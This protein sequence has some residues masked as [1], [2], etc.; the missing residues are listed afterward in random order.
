MNI[1]PHSTV[2]YKGYDARLLRGF[3][4]SSNCGRIGN[5]MEKIGLKEGFKIFS[6]NANMTTPSCCEGVSK[7]RFGAFNMW[8]QDYWTIVKNK[9]LTICFDDKASAIKK[10]FNLKND[11]TQQATRNL[12]AIDAINNAVVD[13]LNRTEGRSANEPEVVSGLLAAFKL[14][15]QRAKISE[16][17][18]KTHIEGG[19]IYIVK[20]DNGSEVIVGSDRKDEFDEEDI[21][22]MYNAQKVTTLPM[23]DYHI[24][25]FIRPLNKKQI[26]LTDDD[27]TLE[28]L[29]KGY[30]KFS[31]FVKSL[32][33]DEKVMYQKRLDMMRCFMEEFANH[34][35]ENSMAKSS[36][37]ASVLKNNG[38]KVIRVPGRVYETKYKY[39]EP[40]GI[41]H[42]CN[43][44]NA[45][46]LENKDGELVYITNKSR[47]DE[48]LGLN[49]EISDKIGFSFETEFIKSISEY[50]KP[51][52]IYFVEGDDH[53]VSDKMLYGYQGGIHCACTEVPFE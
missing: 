44:I 46:V 17:Q 4:M 19:N 33:N 23:M 49:K 38:Y 52:H 47:V 45:N 3:L 42:Y 26:L 34:I 18:Y 7:D 31:S 11:I 20:G 25:L 30:H 22:A 29:K 2:S 40:V 9:L 28:V 10:F 53:Y 41:S 1:N 24:D 37:V 6:F 35:N 51:E 5:E 16:I 39:D 8:A 32:P 13:I 21:Q 12:P 43:Y 36:E 14:D 48:M 15:E 50:V 27:M